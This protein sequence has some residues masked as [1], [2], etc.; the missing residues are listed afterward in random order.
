MIKL[1][2]T[3]K[4]KLINTYP[5]LTSVIERQE[6]G[7]VLKGILKQ[8]QQLSEA[9]HLIKGEKG[10][11]GEKGEKGDRGDQGIAGERGRQGYDGNPGPKGDRGFDGPMGLRGENGKDGQN[12]MELSPQEIVNRINTLQKAINASTIDGIP[13]FEEIRRFLTDPKSKGRIKGKELD[14]SDLRWHGGGISSVAHDATLTGNGTTSSPLS[15]VGGAL[16]LVTVTGTVNDSNVTFTSASQP[17]ILVI[18]GGV[19]RTTG[20]SITWTYLAGTITLSVAVGSGGSIF[21]I[22]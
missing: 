13:T 20:G 10:D 19:Y 21:G 4:R 9:V 1:N 17:T 8:Q 15:V 6:V 12:A 11:Q 22:A 7:D 3:Q 14:M 2:S 18:N 16:T 5:E